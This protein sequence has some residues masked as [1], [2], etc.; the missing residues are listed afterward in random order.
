MGTSTSKGIDRDFVAKRLK[1]LQ[2]TNRKSDMIWKPSAKEET[3]R[4]VPYKFN[5]RNPFIELY[6]H[7]NIGDRTILSPVSFNRPDPIFEVAQKLKGT[8]DKEQWKMGKKLEPKL[9]TFAPIVVRGKEHEGVK[10]WGFGKTVYEELL[11]YIADPEWGDI[12]DPVTGRDM[13]VSSKKNE[14]QDFPTTTVRIQPNQVPISTDRELLQRIVDSQIDIT[15]LYEEKTYEELE[16]VLRSHL[17]PDEKPAENQPTSTP[18]EQPQTETKVE[19][20]QEA[21]AETQEPAPQA[22][23]GD[24]TPMSPDA[25]NDMFGDLFENDNK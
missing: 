10:F 5:R 7:Y 24:D 13:K 6:F 18:A 2:K 14:G 11:G 12:T 20:T 17:N 25:V 4:I 21:P 1:D 16:A 22:E 15:E 8:N 9:R 19:E 23:S 3:I